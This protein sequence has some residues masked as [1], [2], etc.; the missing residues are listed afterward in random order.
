MAH[1][2]NKYDYKTDSFRSYQRKEL[3]FARVKNYDLTYGLWVYGHFPDRVLIKVSICRFAK[4]PSWQPTLALPSSRPCTGHACYYYYQISKL[5]IKLY[6]NVFN[7]FI[8]QFYSTKH[9]YLSLLAFTRYLL[10]EGFTWCRFINCIE[11][12]LFKLFYTPRLIRLVLW[13]N[14]TRIFNTTSLL[15]YKLHQNSWCEET[16]WWGE[17]AEWSSVIK[18]HERSKTRRAINEVGLQTGSQRNFQCQLKSWP[19]T[20]SR[21]SHN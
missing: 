3:Q 16:N 4:A 20:S 8:Q 9:N 1:G 15:F 6:F 5:I 19:E 10:G 17:C 2:A 13:P 18:T 7:Q 21:S 12:G 14:E 11:L